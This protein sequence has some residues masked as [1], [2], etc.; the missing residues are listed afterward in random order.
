MSWPR[1]ML[2]IITSGIVLAALTYWFACPCSYLP[3]GP[4]SGED[5]AP[6]DDWSFVNDVEQVRLCQIEVDFAIARSMHVNCME[7]EGNLYVSC[8][9]CEGK[10][11]SKRALSHPDGFVR[12]AGKVYPIR[13]IRV[14]G[15]DD[16]DRIWAAR[17]TKLGREQSDRPDHWWS[18]NLAT[19]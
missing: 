10:Q 2:G 17:L 8:S 3:G 13:Y 11:W 18:F 15:E 7:S 14:T 16:L 4:L 9:R 12:A 5:A 6:P 19:R 1:V